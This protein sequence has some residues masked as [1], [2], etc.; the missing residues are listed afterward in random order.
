[1]QNSHSPTQDTLTCTCHTCAVYIHLPRSHSPAQVA[2][3]CP[4]CTHLHR[5]HSP[6]QVA[7]TCTCTGRNRVPR[8]QSPAQVTLTCTGYTHLPRSH[9]YRSH[10]PALLTLTCTVYTHLH[11]PTSHSGLTA[12]FSALGVYC[13]SEDSPCFLDIDMFHLLVRTC[14]CS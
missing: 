14:Y 4:G 2:L 7:L 13:Q 1:M 5:S 8:S 11:L 6:A 10:S 12:L 3:T 9:L